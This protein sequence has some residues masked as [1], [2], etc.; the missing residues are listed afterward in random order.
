MLEDDPAPNPSP[1][2]GPGT[3]TFLGQAQVAVIDP[4]PQIASHH[5]AISAAG[6]GRISH[7]FRDPR[8]SG[9]FR[10]RGCTG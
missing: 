9:P 7:I 8:P 2:T 5:E 1:L 6:E 10:R 4:G 3:N